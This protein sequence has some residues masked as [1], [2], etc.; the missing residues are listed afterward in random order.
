MTTMMDTQSARAIIQRALDAYGLS[1]L[2]DYA[3]NSYL[4]GNPIEQI[5]LDIRDRPEYKARFPAMDYLAQNGRAITENTYIEYE[6]AV[7]NMFRQ[8]GIPEGFYDGPDDFANF[9]KND[10]SVAEIAQRVQLA[11]D[12]VYNA[13]QQQKDQLYNLYGVD[14]GHAMAYMLDPQRAQPILSR[15]FQAAERSGRFK[16][17]GLGQLSAADAERLTQ[18][19]PDEAAQQIGKLGQGRELLT[20][21]DRGEADIDRNTQI[22]ALIGETS[23]QDILTR[24]AE[25]RQSAFQA[26]GRYAASREGLVV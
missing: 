4:D 23:A 9:L 20:A 26:G 17:A 7:A 5:M 19:S 1:G 24:R 3:W 15:Q 12:S 8:Y 16:M 13:P 21:L 14:E 6:R 22:G 18:L 11:A 2:G 25:R 10:V